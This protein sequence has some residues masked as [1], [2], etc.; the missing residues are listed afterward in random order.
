MNKFLFV[1]LFLLLFSCNDIKF[2][3]A[4]PQGFLSLTA[5]PN[6]LLGSYYDFKNKDTL[7][8]T[9]KS[10]VFGNKSSLNFVQGTLSDS[11][12]LKQMDNI[13]FINFYENKL[14]SLV[15][16]RVL[17]NKNLSIAVFN[18]EED[19]NFIP[20]VKAIIPLEEVY[21]EDKTI[22]YYIAQP[23]AVQLKQIINIQPLSET[24]ELKRISK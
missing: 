19:E 18:A 23:S 20:N 21:S 5:F 4:Q 10:F 3:E 9:E 2:K 8:V 6:E 17:Q 7:V 12:K 24:L 14:W 16:A 13:Y 1:A 15:M 11:T 22:E